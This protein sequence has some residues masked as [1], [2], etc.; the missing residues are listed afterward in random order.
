VIVTVGWLVVL[1]A[2]SVLEL[3]AWS[4][5]RPAALSSVVR[6]LGRFGPARIAMVALWALFG[7]HLFTRYTVVR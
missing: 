4:S 6:I 2:L 1:A 7:W 5:H 3:L